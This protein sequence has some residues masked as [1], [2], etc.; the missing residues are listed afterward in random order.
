M[1]AKDPRVPEM[2]HELLEDVVI[3]PLLYGCGYTEAELAAPRVGIANTWT[4]L[5][6]GHVHLDRLAERVRAG[7]RSAGMT[8]FGFNTIAP[9]DGMSEGHEGMHYV[10][11]AREVISDSVEI[12]A[13]V[14]RLD[15]LV[16]IGSCDKIV[17]GLLMAAARVDIPAIVVTGGYHL[18]YCCPDQDFA[19]EEEF[20]HYEIGKFF[21]ARNAG[22]IS[23]EVFRKAVQGIVTGP[24]AC[25]MIGTAVTMQCMTEALGMS[26]PRSSILMAE[27]EEKFDFAE[28]AGK[29]IR[30]LID[31]GITPSKI[32]TEKALRNAITVL[33]TMGGSTNGFLHLPAVAN[34]LHIPIPIDLFDELSEK[35]PQTCAVKPNGLRGINSI[36]EAGGIPAV[37]KNISSLLDLDVLTVS[38]RKLGEILEEA[39]IKDD[40]IIR[41]MKDPFAPDG[42]LTVLRGNL[43]P[44]GAIVKK[45]AVPKPMFT[46]RGPARVFECEEDAIY[47]MFNNLVNPGECVIIRY[48]G[49]KGGPGMREMAIPAHLLQLLGLGETTALL[50]DGRYSGS[51]YG[52]CIGHASPEAAEGG[53]LAV[54]E[55]GDTIEIDIPNR[56]LRLDIPE[57]ELQR[58]RSAWRP[59][60]PKHS[61]GILSWYAR[62]VT[63][64]DKGAVLK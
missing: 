61:K 44:D 29:A 25:P 14:N 11:P 36:D 63:S 31:N 64:G 42:G 34:E 38:G 33:H 48:E 32:M 53:P 15:G 22:T 12:M 5:N 58:R 1:G 7:I 47:N 8:P 37:M 50:T 13:R 52:M 51:N 39:E 40:T 43:A 27:S 23:Q 56:A 49:P 46:Y 60:K 4:E 45:S 35:T 24:G 18:P 54:V 41:P 3:P 62:N 30:H 2:I 21:F 6:P 59:P 20:A 55:D 57:D 17:P 16:L 26:L 9:C 19:E 28:D 10:L